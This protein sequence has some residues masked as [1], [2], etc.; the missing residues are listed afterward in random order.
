MGNLVAKNVNI[1]R[2]IF[3]EYDI[4]GTADIDPI[5]L[6]EGKPP[7]EINLTADQA[8]LIGK[9][10]GTHIR[11]KGGQKIVIGRDTRASSMSLAWGVISGLRDVGCDVYELGICTTPMVYFATQHLNMDGGVMITG[12]HNPMWSNGIKM[13]VTSTISLVGAEVTALY[14]M[15]QAS[16]F[17]KGAGRII[18]VNIRDAYIDA[19]VAH[20]RPAVRPLKV[21]LDTGNATGAL[22]APEIIRR[23]GYDVVTINEDVIYP[24]PN[25]APDPEQPSKMIALG[26][27]VVELGADIGVAVDGDADRVGAVDREGNKLE[28]DLLLLLYS[29]QVLAENPGAEIIFDVKC[30]DLLFDDIKAHGGSAMMWKTGHSVLKA[31]LHDEAARGKK[32]LLAGELSGHIFF[33]DRWYGFD[34]GVY[35]ACRLLEIRSSSTETIAQML[36]SLPRLYS[37]RELALECTDETK[38]QIVEDLKNALAKDGYKIID[39]DGVRVDFGSHEWALVRPSNTQPKLTARFC[40]VSRPHLAEVTDIV[41]KKLIEIGGVDLK[42]LDEG[43]AEAE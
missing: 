40:A 42:E 36:S 12:S 4:R 35:S 38:F 11:R 2:T 24:F 41:R 34:D 43:L 23:L 18:Q 1:D 10:F 22:V 19:V 3:R 31:K 16:D 5:E 27:K 37:T 26:K 25:G 13:N 30:T 9:A 28:S 8:F 14:D 7:R 17:E 21:V 15:I 33:R 39:I 20:V 6:S 32:A 29:R